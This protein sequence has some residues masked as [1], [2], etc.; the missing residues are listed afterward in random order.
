MIEEVSFCSSQCFFVA[1]VLDSVSGFVTHHIFIPPSVVV[2]HCQ[3]GQKCPESPAG[4]SVEKSSDMFVVFT[5]CPV[6]EAVRVTKSGNKKDLKRRERMTD[7][8]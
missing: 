6:E 4:L 2:L 3:M 5:L 7:M 8:V 1:I